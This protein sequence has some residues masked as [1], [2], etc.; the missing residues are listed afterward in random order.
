MEC[1][2]KLEEKDKIHAQLKEI[3]KRQ[4]GV[5]AS[6]QLN[7]LQVAMRERTKQLKAMAAELNLAHAQLEEYQY[8]IQSKTQENLELKQ[9]Y[10]ALK[11]SE[12]VFHEK[13][14][15]EKEKSRGANSTAIVPTGPRFVGGGFSLNHV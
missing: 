2:L 6:K 14:R 7:A 4:P 13:E 10:F 11:K 1:K 5:E 12:Y 3:L 15:E 9:K 8:E